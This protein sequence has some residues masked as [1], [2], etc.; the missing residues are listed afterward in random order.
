MPYL[1]TH[2]RPE[3]RQL[4]SSPRLPSIEAPVPASQDHAQSV[5]DALEEDEIAVAR[6]VPSAT[7]RVWESLLAPRG[8]SKVGSEL[9][10]IAPAEGLNPTPDPSPFLSR[11]AKGKGK[12]RA[13]D[14]PDPPTSNKGRSALAKFTR[15]KSFAPSTEPPP[16]DAPATTSRQPFRKA[17]SLFL[18]RPDSPT[19]L[20]PEP[21][22]SPPKIFV[23]KRFRVRAEARS[24]SVRTAIESCGGTWVEDEDDEK[25]VDFVIVR[26]VRYAFSSL[27]S[28]LHKRS[29][30]TQWQ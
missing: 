22:S 3:R 7:L 17:Q 5:P 8:Y 23:G 25:R 28:C 1:V 9:I 26:L 13:L 27:S 20:A 19:Q 14:P 21:N 6:R 10:K 11:A 18:P 30:T 15:S 12:A 2:P 4:P 16:D 29:H 24:A